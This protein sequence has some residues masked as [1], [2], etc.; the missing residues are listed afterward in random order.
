MRL[1]LARALFCQPELLLLDEP[2]NM[3]DVQAVLWLESYLKDKWKNTLLVISHDREFLNM[4]VTDVIHFHE[5]KLAYYSGNYDSFEIIR[6]ER[7]LNQKRSFDAQA[8]HKAHIQKFIDKFRFN[9]KRASLVQSRLKKLSKMAPIAAV[10]EDPSFAFSFPTPDPLRP[11]VIQFTDVAFGYSAEK[12]LF[13]K[14]NFSFDMESR[15]ALVGANGQGKSTILSLIC[16]EIKP[17]TGYIF[18]NA[19][20][21]IGKF[22]QHHVDQMPLDKS[23]IEFLQMDYP[24]KD[25]QVYRDMLGRYGISGDMVF[26]KNSSLSGGQKSRVSFAHIGMRNPHIIILDEPT[27]HLDIDTVDVLAQALNDFEGGVILVSHNERLFHWLAMSFGLW[28]TVRWCRHGVILRP[29]KRS[30]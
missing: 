12:I 1:A 8:A 25:L 6:N 24:G 22:S 13:Q 18:R 26:Q 27:N 16:D 23:P 7:L 29:T 19:R 11:P 20:I 28:P 30:C 9:A 3:L 15:I 5:Q 10:I 4:V 14:L 2:T 21:R 17:R